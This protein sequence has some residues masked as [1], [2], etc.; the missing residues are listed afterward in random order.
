VHHARSLQGGK[1]G[2][3][4]AHTRTTHQRRNEALTKVPLSLGGSLLQSKV[5]RKDTRGEKKDGNLA[6]HYQVEPL[7]RGECQGN[8]GQKFKRVD[9]KFIMAEH[10]RGQKWNSHEAYF[11]KERGA[12]NTSEREGLRRSDYS[13]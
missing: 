12:G 8:R 9:T 2:K 1:R 3:R 13:T 6:D 10:L 11:P 5:S 7:I 4:T